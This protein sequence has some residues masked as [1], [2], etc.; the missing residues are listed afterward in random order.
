MCIAVAQNDRRLLDRAV[1]YTGCGAI[2][3]SHG[4]RRKGHQLQIFRQADV[5][6]ILMAIE[7]F[8]VLKQDKAREAIRVVAG[9]I[10]SVR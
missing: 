5:L 10:S 4:P 1:E 8:L 9:Y 6:R 3:G 2:Y 7:P